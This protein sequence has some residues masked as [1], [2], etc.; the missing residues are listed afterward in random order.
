MN[1][2]NRIRIKLPEKR[3]SCAVSAQIEINVEQ[4]TNLFNLVKDYLVSPIQSNHPVNLPKGKYTLNV[5]ITALET[6][7]D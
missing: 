6:I 2:R 7:E 1:E 3:N 4:E 5:E